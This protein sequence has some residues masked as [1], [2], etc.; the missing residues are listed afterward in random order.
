MIA[1]NYLHTTPWEL[2]RRPIAWVSMALEC[3][4]MESYD[5]D[6]DR[7]SGDGGGKLSS[8]GGGEL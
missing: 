2:A 6:Q 1:A 7:S 3:K 5:P 8:I 4:R